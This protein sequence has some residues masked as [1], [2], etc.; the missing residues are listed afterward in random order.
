[1][2]EIKFRSW[3]ETC[4]PPRYVFWEELKTFNCGDVFIN[5]SEVHIEQFTGLKDKNGKDIYEGDL[6]K[7]LDDIK[8][9]SPIRVG[10][11][12]KFASFSLI[13]KGWAFRHFFGE[14]CNSKDCEV[15]GNIHEVK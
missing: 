14:A 1:M 11:C 15:I 13:R 5:A 10:W 6:I 4:A 12:E 3:D 9:A 2:R 7:F 8:D